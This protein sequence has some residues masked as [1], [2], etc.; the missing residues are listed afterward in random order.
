MFGI[1][2]KKEEEKTPSCCCN[3]AIEPVQEESCCCG[4]TAKETRACCPD[5]KMVVKVPEKKVFHLPET[6]ALII[7]TGGVYGGKFSAAAVEDGFL[8][9]F[10]VPGRNPEEKEEL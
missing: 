4:S 9:L 8:E 6:G 2:K 3:A 10:S 7:D 1:G 5:G